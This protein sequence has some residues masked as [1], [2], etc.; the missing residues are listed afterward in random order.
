[1]I[2]LRLISNL[3]ISD[4]ETIQVMTCPKLGSTFEN[5]SYP[6]LH[7]PGSL[8]S[9]GMEDNNWLPFL[10]AVITRYLGG[11]FQRCA[12]SAY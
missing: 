7:S 8:A 12:Y 1:M 4:L 3:L 5:T 2:L 11:T 10:R 9:Y 6:E